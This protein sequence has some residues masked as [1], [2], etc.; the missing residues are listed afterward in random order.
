MVWGGGSS[1]VGGRKGLRV[2]SD[3]RG[4]RLWNVPAVLFHAR[5]ARSDELFF[6]YSRWSDCGWKVDEYYGQKISLRVI[7]I[8][9]NTA[10]MEYKLI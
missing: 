4:T 6:F 5:I 7:V 10:H 3:C 9:S 8:W 1:A 2:R